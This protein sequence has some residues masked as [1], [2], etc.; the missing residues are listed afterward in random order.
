[1]KKIVLLLF[2]FVTSFA[3]Y[4]QIISFPDANLKAKL[5]SATTSNGV[6]RNASNTS[7]VIDTNADS[8]IQ[9]SEALQVYY[10]S[11]NNGGIT[12]LVGI[13]NFLNLTHLGCDSNELNSLPNLNLPNL[14]SFSCGNNNLTSLSGIENLVNLTS[15]YVDNNPLISVNVSNFSQLLNFSC[16]YTTVTEIDLCGTQVKFFWC[17]SNS[18]LT[19]LKVKNNVITPSQ[20]G[21]RASDPGDNENPIPPPLPSFYFN[22]LPS[23]NYVCYDQAEYYSVIEALAFDYDGITLTSLCTNCPTSSIVNLKLQI[24]GYYNP[25]TNLMNPVKYNQGLSTNFADV[26]DITVELRNTSG[27]LIASTT[28]T[29]KRDGSALCAFPNQ[30]TGSFYIGVKSHNTIKTWSATP[31]SIGSTPITYQFSNSISKA[32][33]NNLVELNNGVFG[34]YSADLN[35]DGNIDNSDYSNWEVDANNFAFGFY[36]TDLNGDGNVDNSDFSIWETNNNNFIYA[37]TPFP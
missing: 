21:F 29:L 35:N 24:Q 31:V 5:L 37:V 23:L 3:S 2:G 27:D 11:L 33:G 7:I 26:E 6:A 22:N 28:S 32:Y 8:E 13:E 16:S 36:T 19:T 9:F 14:V 10:L 25:M 12:S 18:L 4:S 15:L 34:L 30:P 1:M 17:I 20:F